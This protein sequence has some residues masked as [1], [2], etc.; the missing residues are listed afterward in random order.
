MMTVP[1]G[2]HMKSAG[3]PSGCV[4]LA[5]EGTWLHQGGGSGIPAV[6]WDEARDCARPT[7]KGGKRT[8]PTKEIYLS[9]HRFFTSCSKNFYPPTFS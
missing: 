8:S 4:K 3:A 1:V 2:F 9:E 5:A 7:G 6:G